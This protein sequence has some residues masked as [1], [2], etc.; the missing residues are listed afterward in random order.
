MHLTLAVN[1]Q[2]P[3]SKE[4]SSSWSIFCFLHFLHFASKQAGMRWWPLV[5]D[6]P[7]P[8]RLR[9]CKE[10]QIILQM[11]TYLVASKLGLL[12]FIAFHAL[13]WQFRVEVGVMPK[14]RSYNSNLLR[15]YLSLPQV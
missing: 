1:F 10:M 6:V 7:L 11:L 15:L 2:S 14:T 5:M 8:S 12:S 4:D 3:H 9:G 13:G